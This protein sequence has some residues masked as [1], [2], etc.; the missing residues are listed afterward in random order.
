L[1]F[2]LP[3]GLQAVGIPTFPISL[4]SPS[5]EELT[6][7]FFLPPCLQAV[8]LPYFLLLFLSFFFTIPKYRRTHIGFLPFPSFRLLA[9]HS[10]FHFFSQYRLL[11]LNRKYIHLKLIIAF[12]LHFIAF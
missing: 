7:A 5:T 1:S 6:L 9:S 12:L 4:L 8:D 3:P 2:F 11:V 10:L